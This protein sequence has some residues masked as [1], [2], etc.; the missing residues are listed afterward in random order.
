MIGTRSLTVQW[1]GKGFAA[2]RNHC[3]MFLSPDKISPLAHN[4]GSAIFLVVEYASDNGVS[5]IQLFS[6]TESE[7]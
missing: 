3:Q 1:R 4:H 7:C 6:Y 5:L 2:D